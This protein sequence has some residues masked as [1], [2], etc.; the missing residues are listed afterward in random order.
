MDM[1]DLEPKNNP[2]KPRDLTSWDVEELEEYIANMR[3]EITRV[4]AMIET[5]KQISSDASKLFK[6]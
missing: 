5:K 3:V 1:E 6:N 4:E 2:P